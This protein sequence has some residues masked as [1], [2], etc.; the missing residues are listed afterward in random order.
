MSR[1]DVGEL[2]T[3]GTTRELGRQEY[4]G[5]DGKGPVDNTLP[6][7]I[8]STGNEVRAADGF[9]R[10]V[11]RGMSSTRNTSKARGMGERR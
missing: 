5:N 7:G 1:G 2:N 10:G 4:G 3:I 8:V 11:R 6:T 9:D